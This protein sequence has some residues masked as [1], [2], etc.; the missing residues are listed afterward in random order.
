MPNQFITGGVKRLQVGQ[1]DSQG[2]MCGAVDSLADGED[3]GMYIWRGA[4]SIDVTNPERPREIQTGDDTRQGFITFEPTDFLTLGIQMGIQDLEFDTLAQ[5]VNLYDDGQFEHAPIDPQIDEFGELCILTESTAKT[6]VFGQS[7]RKGWAVNVFNRGEVA[8]NGR[9]ST[10]ERQLANFDYLMT[11]EQT[12]TLP[13]GAA[14][15][16]ANQGTQQMSGDVFFSDQKVTLHAVRG[17]GSLTNVTLDFTP[18]G[19]HTD[20]KVFKVYITD[21]ATEVTTEMTPT[22]DY[23]VSG[24]TFTFTSA[25]ASGKHVVIRYKHV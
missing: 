3:S 15:T 20:A 14:I 23:T 25:L 9:D 17:D 22:T 24:T 6:K 7:S 4:K 10:T 5:N 8:V 21:I 12:F 16:K 19:T 11:C 18:T 13:W 2:L 1:F